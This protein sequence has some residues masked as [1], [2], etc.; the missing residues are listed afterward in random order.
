MPKHFTQGRRA[1]NNTTNIFLKIQFN[2]NPQMKLIRVYGSILM[3]LSLV[4]CSALGKGG[5]VI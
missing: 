5:G 1:K 3:F 4:N 2:I